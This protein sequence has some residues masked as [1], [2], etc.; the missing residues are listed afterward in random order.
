MWGWLPDRE[1]SKTP[2][3][4]VDGIREKARPPARAAT[5]YF[6]WILVIFEPWMPMPAMSPF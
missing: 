3:F 4:Q 1:R 5:T 2:K 6:G